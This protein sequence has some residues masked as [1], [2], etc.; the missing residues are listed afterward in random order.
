[1]FAVSRQTSVGERAQLKKKKEEEEKE[2]EDEGHGAG[3]FRAG[4]AELASSVS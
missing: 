4:S 2:E 1:L 3:V